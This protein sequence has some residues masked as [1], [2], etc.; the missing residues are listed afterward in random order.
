MLFSRSGLTPV[1]KTRPTVLPDWTST[2]AEA[3]TETV[4]SSAKSNTIKPNAQTQNELIGRSTP[5]QIVA[6]LPTTKRDSRA[7]FVRYGVRHGPQN[8]R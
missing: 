6:Y 1:L 2:L 8:V 4:I 3:M 7:T 5:T